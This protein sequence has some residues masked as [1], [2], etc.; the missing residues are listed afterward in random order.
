MIQALTKHIIYGPVLAQFQ[1][2]SGTE[3][4]VYGDVIRLTGDH[5][6]MLQSPL[7]DKIRCII[8]N[9]IDKYYIDI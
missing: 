3:G 5:A 2:D 8:L 9:G 4:N 6:A 7:T 1:P